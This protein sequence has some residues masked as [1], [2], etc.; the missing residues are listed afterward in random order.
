MKRCKVLLGTFVEIQ[1]QQDAGFS[2]DLIQEAFADAY[3]AIAKVDELMNIHRQDSA[4]SRINRMALSKPVLIDAWIKDVLLIAQDLY[5]ESNGLF[6][7]TYEPLRPKR[8][9]A[10][11]AIEWTDENHLRFNKAIELNLNGIAKGFAVDK[12]VEVL[13]N[14]GISNGIV[15]AGG[16]LR[17]FGSLRYPIYIRNPINPLLINGIGH[18]KNIAVASSGNYLQTHLFNPEKHSTVCT[19]SSFTVFAKKCAYADGLTKVLAA[20]GHPNHPCFNKFDSV[21]LILK[22]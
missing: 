22:P 3:A 21:A 18:L 2:T 14:Y 1:C 15:N 7:C 19:D 11:D 16:D 5:R 12:A 17:I 6:D 9:P 13:E 4:L 10:F 8:I 20:L